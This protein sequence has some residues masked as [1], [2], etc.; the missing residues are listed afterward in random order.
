MWAPMAERVEVKRCHATVY[1][2]TLGDPGS[3]LPTPGQLKIQASY[4]DFHGQHLENL[5]EFWSVLEEV[6]RDLWVLEP[7]QESHAAS[8]RQICLGETC[9]LWVLM[10]MLFICFFSLTHAVSSTQVMGARFYY[11]LMLRTQGQ[12][13][14]ENL[15]LMN[16]RWLFIPLIVSNAFRCRFL[17]PDLLTDALRKSWR[18][19]SSRWYLNSWLDLTY[20]NEIPLHFFFPWNQFK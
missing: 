10:V 19:N 8:F 1:S 4:S 2:G 13:P 14:S 3:V 16:S 5:Q 6:D 11:I 17:G 7:R 9:W 18:K 20:N 15:P 12:S